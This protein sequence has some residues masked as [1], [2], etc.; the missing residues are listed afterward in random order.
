MGLY[1]GN[2]FGTGENPLVTASRGEMFVPIGDEDS[3]AVSKWIIVVACL[4]VAVI[5]IGLLVNRMYK[6]SITLPE[7]NSA[8]IGFDIDQ[9]DAVPETVHYAG[10][11]FR[12]EISNFEGIITGC[13]YIARGSW[14][15]LKPVVD[16][17]EKRYGTPDK[18]T[19]IPLSELTQEA[20]SAM[21]IGTWTWYYGKRSVEALE[22]LD[23]W[24]SNVAG[25]YIN[26]THL[27][28]DLSVKA[29]ADGEVDV[30]IRYEVRPKY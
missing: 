17:L 26:P 30:E 10:V 25:Y 4:L 20:V 15:E 27:Y 14:Q 12:Y 18:T 11:D 29:A 2:I 19:S 7:R 22:K 28:M 16:A 6:Q 13:R 23:G 3:P 24:G 9:L 21:D 1:A 8:M 5:S